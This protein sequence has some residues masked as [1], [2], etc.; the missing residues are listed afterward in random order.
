M[1]E[2]KDSSQVEQAWAEI[3]DLV[4]VSKLDKF[5]SIHKL[6][7]KKDRDRVVHKGLDSYISSLKNDYASDAV[8]MSLMLLNSAKNYVKL[9]DTDFDDLALKR[10]ISS[11]TY[12]SNDE[13]V[14]PYS[15]PQKLDHWLS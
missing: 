10:K 6:S 4:G 5:L 7:E 1:A 13:W 9:L 15:G 11:L 14:P 8:E 3:E 12:L 2:N